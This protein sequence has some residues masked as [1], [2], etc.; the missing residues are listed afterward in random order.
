MLLWKIWWCVQ[1]I[2][3]WLG[4]N[5]WFVDAWVLLTDRECC[6]AL[7]SS[8]NNVILFSSISIIFTCLEVSSTLVVTLVL[9]GVLDA[10]LS[11]FF[12]VDVYSKSGSNL[13][14]FFLL[15]LAAI[16]PMSVIHLI[17]WNHFKKRQR[18]HKS[19][20]LHVSLKTY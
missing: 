18:I 4:R 8:S 17:Q 7:C 1:K 19:Q 15:G 13:M 14:S 9:T 20:Y 11:M 6:P 2:D 5:G 16:M 10:P 3:W 12:F